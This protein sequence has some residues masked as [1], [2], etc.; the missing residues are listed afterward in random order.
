MFQASR[1]SPLLLVPH[2]HDEEK[3]Q[4]R[5]LDASQQEEIVM[6]RAVVD[7]AWGRKNRCEGKL[8]G[9]FCDRQQLQSNQ[10]TGCQC[11]TELGSHT[12]KGKVP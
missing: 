2:R 7:V 4:R 1:A 3:E 6:Q 10:Q 5:P 9:L 11:H 12:R 8:R